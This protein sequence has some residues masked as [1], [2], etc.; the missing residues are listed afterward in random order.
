MAPRGGLWAAFTRPNHSSEGEGDE[1]A[2][3]LLPNQESGASL[4]RDDVNANTAR[5]DWYSNIVLL[6]KFYKGR[7]VAIVLA[8]IFGLVFLQLA[9]G[10]STPAREFVLCH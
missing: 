7:L 6:S 8:T 3:P 2:V 4:K 1:H 9:F 10:Q 5:G